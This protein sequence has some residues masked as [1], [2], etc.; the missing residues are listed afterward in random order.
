MTSTIASASISRIKTALL[1]QAAAIA[2]FVT[3]KTY[4][5]GQLFSFKD[6]EYQKLILDEFSNPD[7]NLV[8]QKPSQVGISEIIY[9]AQLAWSELVPGFSSAIVFPTR[10]MSN[11]VMSTRVAGII[12][13][14]KTLREAMSRQ[15]DSASVKMLK[16]NSIIYSLG[17]SINSKTTVI[18]RP[19]RLIVVDEL[20]R[21]SLDTVTSLQSRQRHQ[22]H[23]QS[24]MFSTPLFEDCDI[25]VEM[26]NC[27]IIKRF[28]VVCVNC[29]KPFDPDFFEHVRVDKFTDP[30]KT[31]TQE[32]VESLDLELDTAQLYCQ[33]CG[34]P[35]SYNH[36]NQIIATDIISSKKPKVGIKLSAFVLPKYV[37]PR[38]MVRNYLSYTDR[39]EFVQQ[40]L[41][42][43]AKK[44]DTAMDVSKIQFVTHEPTGL[45]VI[46]VDVGKDSHA[47]VAS[48]TPDGM[49]SHTFIKIPLSN[50][51]N[52]VV[53]LA[54]KYKCVAAVVDYMPYT[55]TAVRLMNTIQGCWVAIQV[56]PAQ[57]IPEIFR[58]KVKDDESVGVIK[59]LQI[60]KNLAIDTYV[61]GLMN[62]NLVMADTPL[63]HE[64]VTHHETM[65]RI[66]DTKFI[67]LRYHWV[68]AQG[69]KNKDHWF[70]ANLF[71]YMA[72]KLIT[73]STSL[74][75]P[76]GTLL[77]GFRIKTDL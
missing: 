22:E 45:N 15:V 28:Q 37:Q 73:K 60:N 74:S 9:R 14:S 1:P 55:D 63:K 69:N 35:T 8:V 34:K 16:N 29:Y 64:I 44:Q 2:D 23:K 47:V 26:Q 36:T 59:F 42:L 31:L 6:H 50:L 39:S 53:S 12:S 54:A 30:I 70:Y 3:T 18:N 48:L 67:E 72:T 62:G 46:G 66:R 52:D 10:A 27:G 25:D 51:H 7:S 75:M 41:G 33:H 24:I 71:A 19:L 76:L 40:V 43:P 57:P 68:K 20:A 49:L 13:E 77:G 56:D 11:E 5:N 38:D 58:L 17:A 32:K 65:R 21:C 4:L 61:S